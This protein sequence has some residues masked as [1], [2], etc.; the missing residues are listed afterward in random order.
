MRCL[1]ALLSLL[2]CPSGMPNWFV[3]STEVPLW[4]A[5]LVC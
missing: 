5:L 1:T 3:E 2:R 4:D